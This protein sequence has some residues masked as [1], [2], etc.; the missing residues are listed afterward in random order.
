[1]IVRPRQNWL[2]MLFVWNGSVLQSI[3]PQLVFMAVVST[4][5]VFTNGRI[6]GEKIPLNTA[7]F[8]L[9]GLALAIFL[10][11]RN[12]ASFERFKEA[13]HLWGNLLIAARTL[14]SQI[15]RYLP[16]SVDDAQRN[17]LADWLIAFTYALK[18]ELRHTDPAPDLQRILGPARA[19]ALARKIYKPVAILDELRG[20]I[21]RALGRAPGSEATCWMFDAQLDEL[22]KTVGGCERILST[23][24]PFSYS[25]LLH[26]TVYAYCVLLPFGLVDSTEFF[27][28]L[29]CVFIAYTLI[30]LE[31]I[32]NEVAEPFGLAPNALALDAITRT[33]ERSVLE[34][35]ERDLPDE[36][37]PA[38]TYQIT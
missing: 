12:N 38:S 30:A 26:R 14:T 2:R 37:V 24:I 35:C 9:F 5:A 31:A 18:H 13:R 15:R 20:E 29:I 33:V 8:T 28:P 6:F 4:L 34:L 25:V 32:A 22:G 21:V 23:P 17:R 27:T 11:F 1:M 10:A 7:P 16:D 19:D 36:F 3:I